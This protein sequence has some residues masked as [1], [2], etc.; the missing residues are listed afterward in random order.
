MLARREARTQA[1]LATGAGLCSDYVANILGLLPHD[2][3]LAA[4]AGRLS[5]TEPEEVA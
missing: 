5:A 4:V 3:Q 2:E 1:E